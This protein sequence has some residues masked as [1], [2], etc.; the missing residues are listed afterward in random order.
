MKI[1]F[2]HQNFPGQF[3]F[4]APALV[5]RGHEVK[6]LSPKTNDFGTDIG[7]EYIS[8]KISKSSSKDIHPWLADFEPKIIRAEA[9][10]KEA[11]KLQ[12]N[13]YTPDKIIAHYGWGESLFLKQVWPEAKLGLYCEFFYHSSGADVGFDP[14]FTEDDLGDS[15]RLQ[16]KNLNNYL[17]FPIADGG[18]CPT[19]WQASTFPN[20]FQEKITIVHDGIDTNA[21]RPNNATSIKFNNGLE[22]NSDS[23]IITFVARTLEPYRGYHIFMRSLPKLLAERPNARVMIIGSAE[24]GYGAKPN[25]KKY[26]DLT[27]KN[28]FINE[29][30]DQL[31]SSEWSRVHFLGHLEY[32]IFLKLLQVSTVHVYLTYPFVLSWSLLEA[33]SSGCAIIASD[34]QPLHEAITD[35]ETGILVNFFDHETLAKTIIKVLSDK[36]L[37]LRLGRNARKFAIENY[38]LYSACLPIQLKWVEEL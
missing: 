5:K 15:C 37:R 38:D 10:F 27:W 32:S 22:L 7:I 8:Y 23:E 26:K 4:L 2:I 17:H 18:L 3:K 14:E 24:G 28:I 30:K 34:T 21:V 35:N 12:I 31:S 11:V 6:V 29:L 19:H 1:L 25:K 36:D 9:C 20:E 33:M 13:G 16:I